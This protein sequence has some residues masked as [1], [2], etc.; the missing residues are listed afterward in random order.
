MWYDMHAEDLA[1]SVLGE[2]ILSTLVVLFHPIFKL[3]FFFL[4]AF[5]KLFTQQQLNLMRRPPVWNIG[6]SIGRHSAVLL[7]SALIGSYFPMIYLF[8]FLYFNCA[9]FGEI[10]N[11]KHLYQMPYH[12]PLRTLYVFLYL[13]IGSSLLHSFM[14]IPTH[15]FMIWD[16]PDLNADTFRLIYIPTLFS[17]ALALF[18]WTYWLTE[19]PSQEKLKKHTSLHSDIDYLWNF[20]RA[21]RERFEKVTG[22]DPEKQKLDSESIVK[23]LSKKESMQKKLEDRIDRISTTPSNS[24]IPSLTISPIISPDETELSTTHTFTPTSDSLV[25]SEYSTPSAAS[26]SSSSPSLDKDTSEHKAEFSLS[27]M[28]PSLSS[29]HS[30]LHTSNSTHSTLTGSS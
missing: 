15:I 1:Y 16:T 20:M 26:S 18:V 13:V 14:F 27:E 29:V 24:Q 8:T 30:S 11:I 4:W 21:D 7:N 23:L 9:Y 10:Y 28:L 12:Y 25:Q 3:R 22:I 19:F 2:M 17:V 6:W 5:Q